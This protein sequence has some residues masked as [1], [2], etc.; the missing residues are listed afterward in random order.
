LFLKKCGG[1]NKK[2]RVGKSV[3]L[4]AV[5][6]EYVRYVGHLSKWFVL[7]LLFN[8]RSVVCCCKGRPTIGYNV[9]ALGAVAEFGAQNCQP[10]TKVDL[11]NC[12]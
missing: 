11:K 9:L 5:P 3:G 8:F 7:V 2:H 6:F 4:L 12:T 1:K 10:S